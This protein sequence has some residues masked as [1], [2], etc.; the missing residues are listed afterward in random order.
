M[1]NRSLK[2]ESVNFVHN[3]AIRVLDGEAE[4]V[5]EFLQGLVHR[6]IEA[7][8]V[9]LAPCQYEIV[10]RDWVADGGGQGAS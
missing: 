4:M 2:A 9:R 5:G 6:A 1:G 10:G 8:K 3:F 7:V